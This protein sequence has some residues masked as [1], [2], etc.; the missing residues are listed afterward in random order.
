MSEWPNPFWSNLLKSNSNRAYFGLSIKNVNRNNIGSIDFEMFVGLDGIAMINIVANLAE[1]TLSGSKVLQTRITHND[2]GTWRPVMPPELGLQGKMHPCSNVGCV[3][4][5][6]RY[7]EHI[8]ARATYSSP[9]IIGIVIAV[10]N[11]G[12]VLAPYTKSDT[13]LSHDGGFTWEEVHKDAHLWEFGDSGSIIVTANNEEPA[14]HVLFT[15]DEGLSWRQ[16]QFSN[17]KLC[18]KSIIMV[19]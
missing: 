2:G 1:A 13:F 4:H 10:G 9:G 16:Y 6:H 17:N 18:I 15:T 12:E 11:V 3:L 8:D 14:D 5:V 19:Q 7:M